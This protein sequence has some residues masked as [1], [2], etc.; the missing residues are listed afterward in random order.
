[1]KFDSGIGRVRVILTPLSRILFG[2]QYS[3]EIAFAVGGL[4]S[5]IWSRRLASLLDLPEN[6]VAAELGRLLS[7]RAL[8]S[9]PSEH[10]RRKLYVVVPNPIWRYTRECAEGEI[11]RAEAVGGRDL[12][13]AYWA[14]IGIEDQPMSLPEG[15]QK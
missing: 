12:I 15:R 3:L 1:M 14:A 4:E 9:F 2:K 11:H 13:A 8:D 6:Q 10:D 5:P 7:I